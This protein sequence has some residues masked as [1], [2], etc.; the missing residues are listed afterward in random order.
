MTVH[1]L[2]VDDSET[3]MAS[4]KAV[5]SHYSGLHL[6]C[7]SDGFEA[8]SVASA[9]AFD[10]VLTD[11]TMP[12]LSGLALVRAL[13]SSPKSAGARVVALTGRDSLF[14]QSNSRLAG[15]DAHLVKP[16]KREQFEATAKLFGLKLHGL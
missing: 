7:A 5:L 3:A 13:K 4:A 9:H 8:L 10:L 2:L 16:F 15:A 14:D 11:L 6:V 12:R 1:A